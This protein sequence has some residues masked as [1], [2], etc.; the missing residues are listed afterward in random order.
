MRKEILLA[1]DMGPRLESHHG[2]TL[3]LARSFESLVDSEHRSA[4]LARITVTAF[5]SLTRKIEAG[6]RKLSTTTTSSAR[7]GLL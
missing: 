3:N 7:K 6:P 5:S 2:V 4:H 1:V